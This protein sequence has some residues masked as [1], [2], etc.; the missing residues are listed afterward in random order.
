MAL[1]RE[2]E[3]GANPDTETELVSEAAAG[4]AAPKEAITKIAEATTDK[5]LRIFALGFAILIFFQFV[6]LSVS[7]NLA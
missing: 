7:R 6:Y 3:L 5:F 1:V 2:V 4:A